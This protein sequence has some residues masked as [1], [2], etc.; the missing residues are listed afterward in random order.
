LTFVQLAPAG[1]RFPRH[2]S[3]NKN[4][5][6]A[7]VGLQ[8]DGRVVIVERNVQDGTFGEFVAEIDVPGELTSVIWGDEGALEGFGVQ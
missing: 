8:T 5:T 1:G 3:I 2:F 6:L 7:A 4:G